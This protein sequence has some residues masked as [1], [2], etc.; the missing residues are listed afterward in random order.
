MIRICIHCQRRILRDQTNT[1]CA[2]VP[3]NGNWR[4]YCPANPHGTHRT[5]EEAKLQWTNK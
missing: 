2:L 4:T 1:W 3:Y 5:I